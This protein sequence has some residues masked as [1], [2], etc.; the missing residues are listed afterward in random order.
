MTGSSARW[1]GEPRRAGTAS[2]QGSIDQGACS[3]SKRIRVG[4]V[5]AGMAENHIAAFR[6][7]PDHYAVEAL[8]DLDG[9]RARRVAAEHDVQTVLTAYDDLLERDLDLIDICTPS[10]LHFGQAMQALAAGR[11]ALVE[12]P[13]AGSLAEVDALARPS[14]KSQSRGR[15][16]L[17]VPLLDGLQGFLGV[18]AAG[19]VG[20]PYVATVETHWRRAAAYY[21]N[22]WRGRFRASSAAASSPMRSMRHDILTLV[23]GPIATV[24]RA[25]RDRR[26]SDRN[27]GLRCA[28]PRNEERR[29]G[30]PVGYARRRGGDFAACVSA[31][32]A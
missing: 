32:P 20:K 12:K 19:L 3:M 2:R 9:D 11:H 17:P 14:G 22:P 25:D 28:P 4:V 18:M 24:C 8:C 5:G 21:D 23:M 30:D 27:R 26:Q 6:E 31:S 1:T 15:A 13:L 29:T 10:N 7:L 16:G